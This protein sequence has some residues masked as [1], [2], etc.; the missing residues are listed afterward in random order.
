VGEK[1][2]RASG[3]V[4]ERVGDE[5][6]CFVCAKICTDRMFACAWVGAD[7]LNVVLKEGSDE[8]GLN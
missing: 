7:V 3:W 4:G 5:R 1:I 2:N 8:D 6:S